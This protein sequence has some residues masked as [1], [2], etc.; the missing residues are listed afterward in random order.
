MAPDL[1]KMIQVG[2]KKSMKAG[3]NI[4]SKMHSK[5]VRKCIQE[6][7]ERLRKGVRWYATTGLGVP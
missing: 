1:A 5:I 6:N 3:S 7:T 4:D 2:S